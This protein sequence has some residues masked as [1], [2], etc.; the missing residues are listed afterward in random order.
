MWNID[1]VIKI[2][3]IRLIEKR[4]RKNT[5]LVS[6]DSE[7]AKYVTNIKGIFYYSVFTVF[8]LFALFIVKSFNYYKGQS[9]SSAYSRFNSS[10]TQTIAK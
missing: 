3:Y 2:K 1:Y 8:I 4:I 9:K 7:I 6:T 5:W 10:S